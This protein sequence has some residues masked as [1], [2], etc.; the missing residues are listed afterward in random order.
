EGYEVKN[1]LEALHGAEHARGLGAE[2]RRA[3]RREALADRG[4]H[5]VAVARR[6]GAHGARDPRGV[7]R[8]LALETER[9]DLER[10]LHLIQGRDDGVDALR[11]ARLREGSRE[12]RA[13]HRPRGLRK[14]IRKGAR[15]GL[16]ARDLAQAELD[17]LVA[18]KTLPE[19]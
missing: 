10:L 6:G 19:S 7:A 9:G 1:R 15:P 16:R 2:E 12:P 5:A 17:P 3:R 13:R 11:G 14:A 8:R 4:H 18:E